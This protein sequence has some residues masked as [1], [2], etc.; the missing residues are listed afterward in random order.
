MRP[1]DAESL[2]RYL[3]GVE[4]PGSPWVLEASEDVVRRVL[5]S[6]PDLG[7][8]LVHEPSWQDRLRDAGFRIEDFTEPL[9]SAIDAVIAEAGN[10]R[11]DE[12]TIAASR[13]L[14]ASVLRWGGA[15]GD[16]LVP[17]SMPLADRRAAVESMREGKFA[18]ASSLPPSALAR[19]LLEPA[20]SAFA[21]GRG[22][23]LSDVTAAAVRTSVAR[24]VSQARPG[25][26][27]QVRLCTVHAAVLLADAE[28]LDRDDLLAAAGLDRAALSRIESEL[29]GGTGAAALA[30]KGSRAP[31]VAALRRFPEFQ[32]AADWLGFR[33]D[34]AVLELVAVLEQELDLIADPWVR[35]VATEALG[36]VA[37]ERVI[38]LLTTAG[39]AR[40]DRFNCLS[41]ASEAGLLSGDEARRI[42][43]K[44]LQDRGAV[45]TPA[46][47]FSVVFAL[48]SDAPGLASIP[49]EVVEWYR[50][51][52]SCYFR[53]PDSCR[54]FPDPAPLLE[55]M[56]AGNAVPQALSAVAAAH[57]DALVRSARASAEAAGRTWLFD[58][59]QRCA[60]L[61]RDP[62]MWDAGRGVLLEEDHG[63][64]R[65]LVR[66]MR[67]QPAQRW[68]AIVL[69]KAREYRFAESAHALGV[70]PPGE[71][72]RLV[73]RAAARVLA[74]EGL[75]P[76]D[77]QRLERHVARIQAYLAGASGATSPR[78]SALD[79][80]RREDARDLLRAEETP[81]IALP[82]NPVPTSIA[83]PA[84]VAA[85]AVAAS[86]ALVLLGQLLLG[87]SRLPASVADPSVDRAA[88]AEPASVRSRA[89]EPAAGWAPIR[90]PHG[91]SVQLPAGEL[92]RLLPV[93]PSDRLD[94]SILTIAEA[95][96]LVAR[97]AEEIKSFPDGA[98]IV[99]SS[100]PVAADRLIVR[101]PRGIDETGEAV[102]P[103]SPM[104]KERDVAR[105][106]P[107]SD[108]P[109][110]PVRIVI[111]DAGAKRDG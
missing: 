34:P 17:A 100:S 106:Q 99:A 44:E 20:S 95:Q 21:S 15:R 55:S 103:P 75:V 107:G 86:M 58:F 9:V 87:G 79:A 36:G 18:V 109:Q 82:H 19:L 35:L 74:A 11:P 46:R 73:D 96:E 83:S 72:R 42:V 45:G 16:W 89:W 32:R 65:D 97:L 26:A 13:L 62:S 50:R 22:K 8:R 51:A 68:Y 92:R 38:E 7:F 3:E 29:R 104:W 93:L 105:V 91:V 52:E 71:F 85:W 90:L 59:V 94:A 60:S 80:F 2:Q 31:D 88:V 81:D 57:A 69:P 78:S 64:L 76:D 24:L 1:G 67:E 56:I 14:A 5:T 28:S 102:D 23:W 40:G 49:P 12:F 43:A 41:I 6:R 77:R 27:L 33:F 84:A 48:R 98:R 39:S 108:A 110:R 101:L 4:A 10:G 70:L 37:S 66:A 47:L 63:V 61:P 30:S 111:E 25:S 54:S 53:D